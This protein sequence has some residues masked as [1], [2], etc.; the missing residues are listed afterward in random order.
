MKVRLKLNPGDRGTKKLHALYGDKLLCVRY[1]SDAGQE[2]RYKTVE[3]VVEEMPWKPNTPP[4]AAASPADRLVAVKVEYCERDLQQR[5][6][7]AGGRW[8]PTRKH[9]LLRQ[10]KAV[11]LGLEDRVSEI[12]ETP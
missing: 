1:R 2:R 9:W 8:E 11:E 7:N 4:A 3:L 12:D 6:R 10:D 5:V